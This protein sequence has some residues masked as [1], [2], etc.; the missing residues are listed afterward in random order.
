M[1]NGLSQSPLLHIKN[2]CNL[3][4]GFSFIILIPDHLW[5]VVDS[6]AAEGVSLQCGC[7]GPMMRAEGGSKELRKNI[8]IKFPPYI[9]FDIPSKQVIPSTTLA[10]TKWRIKYSSFT[11]LFVLLCQQIMTREQLQRYQIFYYHW[12]YVN[13]Y[14]GNTFLGI[15]LWEHGQTKSGK[16]KI[17]TPP[18]LFYLLPFP[19]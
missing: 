9:S 2:G 7:C 17:H 5:S 10:K 3:R 4:K 15:I 16:D 12:N 18:L 14:Q 11:N 13:Y 1:S 8:L 19:F 6:M